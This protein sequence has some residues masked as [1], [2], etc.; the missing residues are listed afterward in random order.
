MKGKEV[1]IMSAWWHKYW[2]T[3][4]DNS[5]INAKKFK[6]DPPRPGR[7][8]YSQRLNETS[9]MSTN[10]IRAKI[11]ERERERKECG[12]LYRVLSDR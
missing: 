12:V 3:K 1:K 6:I 11:S 4:A 5:D 7:K 2:K 8:T 10:E 9:S